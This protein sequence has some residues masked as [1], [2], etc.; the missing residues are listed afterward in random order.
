MGCSSLSLSWPS[1]GTRT[2]D[3][4]QVKP[5][6]NIHLQ[7]VEPGGFRTDWSGRSMAFGE[8][9][10]TAYDHIDAKKNASGRHG[11]QPGDP[12]KAARAMYELAVMKDPPLRCA[13]GSDA[14]TQ[15]VQKAD[16][17]AK[18]VKKFE[19]LSNSTDVDK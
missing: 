8:V 11:T 9:K 17:Y 14:Y 4:F 13:I 3:V 10:N 15:M 1:V 18:E 5:E 6:W 2:D 7:I 19:Q 16:T 12:V